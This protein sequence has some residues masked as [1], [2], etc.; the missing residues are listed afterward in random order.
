MNGYNETPMI[1]GRAE[2]TLDK[3]YSP[4]F[5]TKTI[6]GASPDKPRKVY[7]IKC[8]NCNRISEDYLDWICDEGKPNYVTGDVELM[9]CCFKN[10]IGD[11]QDYK[12][13][14]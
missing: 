7:C 4:Q 2:A 8:D 10:S 5:D 3:V 1:F 13:K 9:H 12:E 14:I 11:C 6:I